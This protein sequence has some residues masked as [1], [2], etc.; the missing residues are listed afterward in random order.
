MKQ[1]AIFSWLLF[2][3]LLLQALNC[4]DQTPQDVL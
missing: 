1:Y 2:D 3:S 4:S